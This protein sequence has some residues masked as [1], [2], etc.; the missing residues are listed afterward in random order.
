MV[1]PAALSKA[2]SLVR[3][4]GYLGVKPTEFVVSLTVGEAYELLDF[5]AGG[6]MG[7]VANHELLVQDIADAKVAC[8]PWDILT[9]WTLLGLSIV[10]AED[11]N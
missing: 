7:R 10:R 8:N 11:L 6:G 4:A 9:H 2:E 1:T 3:H 5:L